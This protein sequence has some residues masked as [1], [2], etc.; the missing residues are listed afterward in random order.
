MP[1]VQISGSVK[2]HRNVVMSEG[3]QQRLW[4]KPNRGRIS[5]AGALDGTRVF[6]NFDRETG[7]FSASVYSDPGSDLYYTLCADW[8]PPQAST[9][10]RALGYFE[11]PERIYPDIGGNIGNMVEVAYGIGLVYVSD[12]VEAGMSPAPRYQLLYNPTTNDL[13]ERR[14]SW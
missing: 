8:L 13:Y 9:E 5:T 6:V 10:E 7:E 14:I 11:W 12:S 1:W 2:D 4:L 3:S